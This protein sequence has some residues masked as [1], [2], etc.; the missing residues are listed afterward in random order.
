VSD[1]FFVASL[2]DGVSAGD[3]VQLTGAEAHH[4]GVVRRLDIGESVTL[5]DGLGLGVLG[6]VLDVS[7]SVVG[8][9]VDSVL[10]PAPSQL[11]VTVAQALPKQDRAE[12]AVDL[13]TEAGVDEILPWAGA[14]SQVR[15]SGERGEKAAAKWVS[16]AREASKQARRFRFPLVDS[17]ASLSDVVECAETYDCVIV[18]HEKSTRPISQCPVP[19]S[20]KV[21]IV[22]GPE[23]GLTDEEVTALEGVGGLTYLMGPTVLRTSTAGAVAVT[24]VRL[25]ADLAGRGDR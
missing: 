14:R 2:P 4:A 8:V 13:M 17:Y 9:E 3:R 10:V 5:T 6:H 25:L 16:A 7:K 22:I 21:L 20:G 15:W 24:Q 23:G 12:L 11:W 19:S 18:M 1:G